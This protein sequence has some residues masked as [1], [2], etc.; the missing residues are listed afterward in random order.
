MSEKLGRVMGQMFDRLPVTSWGCFTTLRQHVA[1]AFAAVF[2]EVSR[3]LV[4]GIG[5]AQPLF[6]RQLS[7]NFDH[8]WTF[9][10]EAKLCAALGPG[11]QWPRALRD[12]QFGLGGTDLLGIS[13]GPVTGSITIDNKKTTNNR[14]REKWNHWMVIHVSLTNWDDLFETWKTLVW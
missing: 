10:A 13:E 7:P 11:Q 4:L 1:L 2:D 9:D 8:P 14:E 12:V 6:W 5:G 3:R